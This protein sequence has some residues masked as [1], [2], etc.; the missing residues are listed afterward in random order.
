MGG[1]VPIGYRA[2]DR[3]LVVDEA[4]A[5]TVRTLFALYLQHGTVQKVA[6]E[7]ARLNLRTRRRQSPGGGETG[8]GNFHRGHLHQLLMNPIYI[9]EIAHRGGRYPGQ[10]QPIVEREIFE[11]V[12]DRIAHQRHERKSR[13]NTRNPSLLA[14]LVHDETGDRLAPVFTNKG[15]RRY[16]YYVSGRLVHR[17][18]DAEGGWRLPGP[19][20]DQLV[21]EALISFLREPLRLVGILGLERSSPEVLQSLIQRAGALA[22]AIAGQGEEGAGPAIRSLVARID[23]APET[24]RIEL[25]ADAQGMILGVTPYPHIRPELSVPIQLRRRGQETRLVLGGQATS[26]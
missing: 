12:Q 14:G 25:K 9:G 2:Q 15:G 10:H 1:P 24:M 20:L 17:A 26:P 6:R 21:R 19:R 11:A 22:D 18:A 7:A 4:E 3:R 5:G 23:L 8:G 16:R 13:C